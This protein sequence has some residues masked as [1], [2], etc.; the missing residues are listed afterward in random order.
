MRLL[1]LCQALGEF[2]PAAE[3][4]GGSEVKCG[5]ANAR[6]HEGQQA[7]AG[8]R[9]RAFCTSQMSPNTSPLRAGACAP[10]LEVV[11]TRLA[12]GLLKGSFPMEKSQTL[13]WDQ[14]RMDQGKHLPH[15]E[16]LSLSLSCSSASTELS[17]PGDLRLSWLSC[18]ING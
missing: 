3:A 5:S 4:S 8:W 2:P 18:P 12:T 11:L 7:L 15:P 9:Q 1:L 14:S 6:G 17:V 10:L 13:P 16:S